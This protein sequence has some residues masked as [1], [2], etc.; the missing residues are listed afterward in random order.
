M[1]AHFCSR[2]LSLALLF[3]FVLSGVARSQG[4]YTS[5]NIWYEK[6]EKIFA[7]NYK[8][9]KILPAGTEV[10]DIRLNRGRRP[11]IT[12]TTVQTNQKFRMYFT[13]KF[14][15][16]LKAEIFKERMFVSKTFA[17]LTADL[18]PFEIEA[19]RAGKIVEGM[20]RKAVL[21]CY[22]F[23]PEHKTPELN[24]P[25]WLYWLN[26]FKSVKVAFDENGRT[27]KPGFKP[28]VQ[29]KTELAQKTEPQI[30]TPP[31]LTNQSQSVDMTPPTITILEPAVTR[32]MRL[33]QKTIMV[34]GKAEDPSGIFEVLVNGTQ[35][36]LSANGDFWAQVLLAVGENRINVRARD[37]KNNFADQSFTILREGSEPPPAQPGGPA[38]PMV[39]VGTGKYFAVIIAVQDYA[40]STINDLDEP[41]RDATELKR[42]LTNYY[43][44]D[45]QNVI[46]LKNPDRDQIIENFENLSKKISKN[47]N[48]LIFYAGHGYWD[49]K[50]QQGYWLPSNAEKDNRAQWISNSTVVDFIRGIESNHTLLITDACFSGG[51]FKTRK[52]F[53]DAPP[54]ISELY[55]L[56]SRK[57]MTSGTLKEVPDK[58]VFVQYLTKRLNENTEK[59]LTA[60]QLFVSFRTAVINNSPVKQIPQFGEIRQAGDE[61][62][63][64][65]FIRR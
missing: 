4:L 19:I 27:L 8:R 6:P 48:L 49:E 28:P 39:Q 20:S 21:I 34:R 31:A 22:G 58:S 1:A 7:I 59:Y 52:A 47:D 18:Q 45:P 57:A 29:K 38:T 37:T 33:A 10:K 63:D 44:F 46:I 54:A 50:F 25:V 42:I 40:S 24:R 61:G 5:F 55:K 36:N 35:A 3:L 23:P 2:M 56:P 43:T 30:K 51:I 12:F 26:R 17:E 41:V 32:G 53:S 62:G 65:V 60:E 13:P 15:G 11:Q 16:K 9:G 64:F 14:H